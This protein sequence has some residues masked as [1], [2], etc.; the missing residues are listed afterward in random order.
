LKNDL[1]I[2]PIFH[3]KDKYIEPHIWLGLLAYQVVNFIRLRLKN[4]NIKYSWSKISTIMQAQQSATVSMNAREGR[5]LYARVCTRPNKQTQQIYE[6]LGCKT[7]PW[8]RKMNVMT[9]K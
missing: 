6:T 2:R 3:Q 5:K 8:V 1:D 4:K 9:Q 7:R